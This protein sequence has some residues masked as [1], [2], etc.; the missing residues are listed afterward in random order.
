[1]KENVD[2]ANVRIP[3][4][5]LY[6]GVLLLAV[7]INNVLGLGGLDLNRPIRLIIGS[8][9][10][11]GGVAVAASARSRFTKLGT[12]VPPW[13]PA[14]LLVTSGMFRWSR[15]PMYLGVTLAYSGLSILFDSVLALV[16]LPVVLLIIRT[17]VI[18][19]EER[20][21]EAKFGA[22]YR[23]Y[24]ARVRRWV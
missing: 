15:N 24:K 13:Q 20:Y 7:W 21:L 12:N 16:L 23:A 9:L 14:T 8:P 4:P 22:D 11:V 2:S 19:R 18:A 3:P 6:L 1:M 17:Q 5:L 10:L